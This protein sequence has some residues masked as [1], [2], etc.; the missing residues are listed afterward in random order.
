M[1]THRRVGRRSTATSSPNP[2]D[3]YN[4]LDGGNPLLEPETADT[5]TAGIVW[6][7]QSISGLSL[8]LDYYDIQISDT[9]GSLATGRHRPDLR[10]HR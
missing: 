7:P 9:I 4:S 2:A 6:T 1:R 3:Q 8:T 10:H 5:I